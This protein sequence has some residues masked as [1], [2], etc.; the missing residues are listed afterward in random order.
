M[1]TIS[2]DNYLK[3][4]QVFHWATRDH[5]AIWYTGK[6]GRHKRTEVMLPR[7]VKKK[8]LTCTRYKKSIIYS[9]PRINRKRIEG[10]QFYPLFE[11]GLGCTE[12]LVRFRRA[13]PT[14]IIIPERELRGYGVVPEWGM[15]WNKGLLL[16]EFCTEDNWRR[17]SLITGKLTRYKRAIFKFEAK[18]SAEAA[19]LFVADVNRWDVDRFVQKVMPTSKNFFFTDYQTF[20][21]TPI[22][23]QLIDPIYIWGMDAW[24]Y[25]LR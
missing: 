5:F 13:D 9:V 16:F 20:L 10:L 23:E 12:G 1:C 24:P 21:K 14:G 25:P 22:G 6:P 2:K 15:L 3:V 7:L 4:A 18:F 11:H 17:R 8:L 19:V